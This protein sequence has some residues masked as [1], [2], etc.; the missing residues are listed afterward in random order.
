MVELGHLV[1]VD[2]VERLELFAEGGQRTKRGTFSA[3]ESV[4][5]IDS[6]L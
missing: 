3:S 5:K 1:D 2:G 6:M 4:E